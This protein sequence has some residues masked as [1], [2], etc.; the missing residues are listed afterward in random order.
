MSTQP[1]MTIGEVAELYGVPTRHVRR[2]FER[3]LLPPAK[4]AGS[5]RVFLATDLP[6]I[7]GALR[8]AGYLPAHTA[9]EVSA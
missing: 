7:E 5:Y 6:A 4:R 9:E 1:V 8:R 3:D 2:L